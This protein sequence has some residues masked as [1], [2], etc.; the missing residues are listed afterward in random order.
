[1]T[2]AKASPKT[3]KSTKNASTEVQQYIDS[4]IENQK[5]VNEALQDARERG[6][7]LSESVAK[8]VADR[9]V[10]ALELAK[11]LATDPKDYRGNVEVMLESL[12]RSQTEA[13]DVFKAVVAE[14]GNVVGEFNNTAKSLLEGARD[15][16]QAA[17]N[18]ARTWGVDSPV[19]GLF[20]QSMTAAKEA[21]EK[22]TKAVA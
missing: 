14:Q 16:S 8:R 4:L 10:T 5:V 21:T 1:M 17:L 18:L 7:R 22:L 3:S 11:K 9:Q 13:F 20:Q 19:S 12:T 6:V 15:T 2:Q